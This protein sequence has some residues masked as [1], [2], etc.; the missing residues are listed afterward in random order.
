VAAFVSVYH[1]TV[2]LL[3]LSGEADDWVP[4]SNCLAFGKQ[5]KPQ[6]AVRDPHLFGVVHMF[7][8]PSVNTLRMNEGHK[9]QYN[10]GPPATAMNGCGRSWTSGCAA[11]WPRSSRTSRSWEPG[12][13]VM[14]RSSSLTIYDE[15]MTAFCGIRFFNSH[16]P[17]HAHPAWSGMSD[18]PKTRPEGIH[19]VQTRTG[20]AA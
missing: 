8:A 15:E 12:P 2:P 20:R 16:I 9:M 14:C 10:Y 3:V 17:F 5:L 6:P 18:G 7:D 1:G 19:P 11:S 13:R 4:P